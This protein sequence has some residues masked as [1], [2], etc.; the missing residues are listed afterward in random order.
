MTN[1]FKRQ[2]IKLLLV[3]MLLF[4]KCS[5]SQP[6]NILTTGQSDVVMID[7][8]T[9]VDILQLNQDFEITGH[10]YK[11]K[12]RHRF[13]IDSVC[14]DLFDYSILKGHLLTIHEEFRTRIDL[15]KKICDDSIDLLNDKFNE[16]VVLYKDEIKKLNNDILD[17]KENFKKKEILHK[18]EL[19]I[20]KW[21]AVGISSVTLILLYGLV[22]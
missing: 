19:K 12:E 16:R 11:E 4:P 22:K 17:L 8:Q 6:V 2:I 13:S 20:W 3:F 15:E 5:F 18:E 1:L 21:T 14:L 10:V 9:K 7:N